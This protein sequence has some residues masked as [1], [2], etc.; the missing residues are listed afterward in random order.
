MASVMPAMSRSEPLGLWGNRPRAAFPRAG[1]FQGDLAPV[2]QLRQDGAIG[3]KFPLPV[4]DGQF[5][6][7]QPLSEHA[8]GVHGLEVD[9]GVPKIA[10]VVGDERRQAGV[11]PPGQ[12]RQQPQ[13]DQ[14]LEAVADADDQ[15]AGGMNSCKAEPRASFSRKARMTP[16]PWSSPQE[17][18]P[19]TARRW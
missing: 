13:V 12:A 1:V 19:G 16:A 9:P 18:P 17:N 6:A 5:Q 7:I 2:G 3:V 14:D 15:A 10:A 8:L 11:G 4:A